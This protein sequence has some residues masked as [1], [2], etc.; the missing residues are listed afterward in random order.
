MRFDQVSSATLQPTKRQIE[1][2]CF[3]CDA[4][5]H[6]DLRAGI[7]AHDKT[8]TLAKVGYTILCPVCESIDRSVPQACTLDRQGQPL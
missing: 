6:V 5:L 3:E 1:G 4:V 2:R 8:S 7:A